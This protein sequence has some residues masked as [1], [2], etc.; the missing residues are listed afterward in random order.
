V[1]IYARVK[2]VCMFECIQFVGV[3][4]LYVCV[5][6]VGFDCFVL[7]IFELDCY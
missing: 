2:I 3:S 4:K 6:Y 1:C 5:Q 7:D